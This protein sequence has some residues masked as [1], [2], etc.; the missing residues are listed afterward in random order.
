MLLL[1]IHCFFLHLKASSILPSLF[2]LFSSLLISLPPSFPLSLSFS[3]Y[4]STA[5]VNSLVLGL[6]YGFSQSILFFLYAPFFRFGGFLVTLPTDNVAYVDFYDVFR[7]FVAIVFG[8]AA[9]AQAGA[10]APD[11]A[12]ARLSANRIFFLL[13]R[14]PKIDNYSTEGKNPVR[15]QHILF[16]NCKQGFL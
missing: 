5:V 11:Y 16:I 9:V 10:F 7:V 8:G 14:K 13:D 4:L 15:A 1:L 6:A 12:Q 2:S 3:P